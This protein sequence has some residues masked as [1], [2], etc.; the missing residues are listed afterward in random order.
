MKLAPRLA[1]ARL[2]VPTACSPHDEPCRGMHELCGTPKD[3]C[4]E[5]VAAFDEDRGEQGVEELAACYA[6][7]TSCA[8]AQGCVSALAVKGAA[9]AV[10]DFLDAF[11]EGLRGEPRAE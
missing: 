1:P 5:L 6:D 9:E 10:A 7:A 4:R 8:R 11:G 3:E 2:V